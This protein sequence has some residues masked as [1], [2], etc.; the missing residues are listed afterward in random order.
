MAYSLACNE[1]TSQLLK[2]PYSSARLQQFGT[3]AN[4]MHSWTSS[5]RILCRVIS[6][7]RQVVCERCDGLTPEPASAAEC[8]SFTS[9][10][11]LAGRCTSLWFMRRHDA[12]I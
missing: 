2:Q 11:I 1:S 9:T 12:R 3:K 8:E 5:R 6:L 10:M 7:P 4:M